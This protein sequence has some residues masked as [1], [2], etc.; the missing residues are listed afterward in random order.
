MR[1][2]SY[3]ATAQQRS[4]NLAI[5]HRG[6][7]AL[8]AVEP[9]LA[10]Q[11]LQSAI[12]MRGRMIHKQTEEAD[13]QLYDRDGQVRL[14]NWVTRVIYCLY[15]TYQCINSIDRALFNEA[16]LN[17]AAASSNIRIFFNCKVVAA[18]FDNKTMVIQETISKKDFSVDFDLC[19]G[20]D[21]SYS[22]IRRQ[23]MRALR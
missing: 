4:I 6:I 21:G 16:L 2:P 3:K 22:I 18:D 14:F 15:Q 19:I 17:E 13:S 1:L 20:A 8:E 10:T 9:S 12:P 7:A 5:S 11:F 23:M